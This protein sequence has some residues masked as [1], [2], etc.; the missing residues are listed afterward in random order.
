MFVQGAQLRS[1][2]KEIS[3]LQRSQSQNQQYNNK[4]HNNFKQHIERKIQ[5]M[6]DTAGESNAA[7]E[8]KLEDVTEAAGDNSAAISNHGSA[9]RGL[10]YENRALKQQVRALQSKDVQNDS[11]MKVVV[12]SVTK[13][14]S[15]RFIRSVLVLVLVLL[16]MMH[17]IARCRCRCRCWCRCWCWCWCWCCR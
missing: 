6:E 4:Q 12:A 17:S 5:G 3:N 9:I 7:M 1:Q 2:Q 14:R 8:R 13:V 11:A 16:L 15:C 10:D